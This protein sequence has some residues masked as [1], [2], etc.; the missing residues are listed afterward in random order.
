MAW[1][2][3]AAAQNIM[4]A[5]FK[6]EAGGKLII[7]AINYTAA[8]KKTGFVPDGL[9]RNK[10]MRL[11]NWYVTSAKEGD[12]LKPYPVTVNQAVAGN[13]FEVVLP[14]RSINNLYLFTLNK[15]G[16]K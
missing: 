6:D 14:A 2:I 4:V 1:Q 13:H 11:T 8:D 10:T 15:F 3:T 16:N 5:A 9:T 7:I 12:D